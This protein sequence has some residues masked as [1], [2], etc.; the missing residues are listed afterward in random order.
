MPGL[1][2]E[3]SDFVRAPGR[4]TF[5]LKDASISLEP[6]GLAQRLWNRLFSIWGYEHHC[7]EHSGTSLD[8]SLGRHINLEDI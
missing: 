1:G 6:H 3:N 4:R 5:R 8:S 7:L 2:C